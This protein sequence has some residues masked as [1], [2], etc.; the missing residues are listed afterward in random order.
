MN[1]YALAMTA[2]DE[3][4]RLDAEA[5]A[6]HP[7]VTDDLLEQNGA[8][9]YMN[10]M[11]GTENTWINDG[12]TCDFMI[13]YASW[14]QFGFIRIFGKKAGAIRVCVFEDNFMEPIEK[15]EVPFSPAAI[16]DLNVAMYYVADD[17]GKFD[18]PLSELNWP[19]AEAVLGQ[20]E[21]KIE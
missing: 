14:P 11:K 17:S 2:L 12:M 4:K 19:A 3:I 16:H 1:R 10:G 7:E 21:A 13:C 6:K 20:Y 15:H 5:R 18:R 8:I 9:Y